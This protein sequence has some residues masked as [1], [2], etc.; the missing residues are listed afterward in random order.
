MALLQTKELTKRFGGL[1]AVDSVSLSLEEG[2]IVGLIGPN[3]AG[4]TTFINLVTGILRPDAGSVFFKG[5]NITHLPSYQR[6]RLGIARTFQIL[7]PFGSLS[8][9]DNILVALAQRHY[10]NLLGILRRRN[11]RHIKEEAEKLLVLTGLKA[12]ASHQASSLPVGILRRLEVARALALRPSLLLLDEPVAG[13][14]DQELQEFQVSLARIKVDF[15]LTI[16]LVEHR[17]RFVMGLCNRI[18]VMHR[19]SLIAEGSPAE[20]ANNPQVIEI[21]L[22]GN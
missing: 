8:V 20:V 4:K 7:R 22:G 9:Q 17:I 6:A 3:G 15:G 13:L 21:Y 18:I 19:G 2:E 5:T 1:R 16:L 11:S 10:S 12:Y 14:N